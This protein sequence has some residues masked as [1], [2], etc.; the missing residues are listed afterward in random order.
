MAEGLLLQRR[1]KR[2]HSYYHNHKNDLAGD[3]LLTHPQISQSINQNGIPVPRT[4]TF[5]RKQQNAFTTNKTTLAYWEK[6][7]ERQ[8]DKERIQL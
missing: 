8:R 1:R 2:F 4:I 7:R 3:T 5:K 6:E